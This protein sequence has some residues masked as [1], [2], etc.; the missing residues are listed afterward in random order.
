M[1][2][3]EGGFALPD[4]KKSSIKTTLID[5]KTIRTSTINKDQK[6]ITR[7]WEPVEELELL[8]TVD[9]IAK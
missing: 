5:L 4:K 1:K 6:E 2:K 3:N 7:S 8:C 9:G